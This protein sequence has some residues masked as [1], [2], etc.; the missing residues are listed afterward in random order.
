MYRDTRFVGKHRVQ[1][2]QDRMLKSRRMDTQPLSH[3][4]APEPSREFSTP[5]DDDGTSVKVTEL[6]LPRL[7]IILRFA[8][9]QIRVFSPNHNTEILSQK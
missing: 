4:L 7:T 9:D 2:N 6:L 3:F 1:E 8:S 5:S